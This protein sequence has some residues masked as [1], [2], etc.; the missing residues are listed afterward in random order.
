[1][2]SVVAAISIVIAALL[3]YLLR[4]HL[5]APSAPSASDGQLSGF[6]PIMDQVP[7]PMSGQ[8]TVASSLPETTTSLLRPY[9]PDDPATYPTYQGTSPP[10]TMAG[11]HRY[12]YPSP[13]YF[14]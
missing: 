5:P 2:P 10:P 3:F 11:M 8:G 1:M 9:N 14:D 7:R 6:N 4:Q 13:E 12:F